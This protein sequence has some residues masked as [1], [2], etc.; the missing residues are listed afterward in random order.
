MSLSGTSSDSMT[1]SITTSFTM[2]TKLTIT[3]TISVIKTISKTSS[4][5]VFMTE[6]VIV[7]VNFSHKDYIKD[8]L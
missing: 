5:I 3:I 2:T 4:D 6:I 8:K 7:M 1:I